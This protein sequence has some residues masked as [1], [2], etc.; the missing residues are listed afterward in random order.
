VVL[1]SIDADHDSST[2]ADAHFDPAG[3]AIGSGVDLDHR[4]EIPLH[5]G[6]DFKSVDGVGVAAEHCPELTVDIDQSADE[7]CG[8]LVESGGGV[9]LGAGTGAGRAGSEEPGG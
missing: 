8:V 7:G 3:G 9:E 4:P 6:F 5:P 1:A 2:V